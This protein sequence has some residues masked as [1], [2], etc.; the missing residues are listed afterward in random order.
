MAAIAFLSPALQFFDDDGNPLAGGFVYTY[1][2]GTSTP[3][4]TWFN[5]DLAIGH[6]NANPI[7]LDAAGR[8]VVYVD[9]TPSL[10]IIV[11]ASD[12]TTIYTQDN[13]SPA[14]VAS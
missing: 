9:T 10:K 4:P 14:A 11:K 8:C 13:I 1:I 12:L 3:S 5:S 7:E 2:A 6:E